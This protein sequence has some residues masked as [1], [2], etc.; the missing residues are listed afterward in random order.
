M[1]DHERQLEAAAWSGY[2]QAINDVLRLRLSK[3]AR[4]IIAQFSADQERRCSL[5]DEHTDLLRL[6]SR[7]PEQEERL[8]AVRDL[9]LDLPSLNMLRSDREAMSI[10]RDAARKIQP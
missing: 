10:I 8:V 9:L 5:D 6:D 2:T 3:K 1:T 4:E 7:T